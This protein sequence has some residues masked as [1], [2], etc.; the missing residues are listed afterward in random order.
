MKPIIVLFIFLLFS[1][2]SKKSTISDDKSNSEIYQTSCPEDGVCTFEILKKKRITIK[3]DDFGK[4]YYSLE[5]DET[6]NTI[7]YVYSLNNDKKIQDSSYREE[8]IFEINSSES[9]LNLSDITIQNTKMLFGRFCFCRGATGYYKVN[10]GN[11]I[12]KKTN[13]KYIMNL[14]FKIHEVPQIITTISGVI[15]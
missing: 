4:I 1:C 8:I 14:V 10:E 7:R 15:K 5:E 13:E 6:K 11:L 3:N 2:S 9:T 12:I